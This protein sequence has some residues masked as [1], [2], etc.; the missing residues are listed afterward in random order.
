MYCTTND[1]LGRIDQEV[2]AQLSNDSG[3]ETVVESVVSRAIADACAEIDSFAGRR[4]ATPLNPVPDII[5]KVAVELSI[6]ALYSRR[7]GAPEEWRTRYE[8]NR[9]WLQDLA[10]GLVSLGEDDPDGSPAPAPIKV[11]SRP[12]VFSRERMGDF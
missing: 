11:S 12:R 4:H 6:Y 7:L 3:G 5:R 1:I 8:D 2:L 10:K 9:R